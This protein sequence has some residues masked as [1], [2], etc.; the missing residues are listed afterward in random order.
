MGTKV[1]AVVAMT[2]KLVE[3]RKL[4]AN[5]AAYSDSVKCIEG[6]PGELYILL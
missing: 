5:P 4:Q 3:A 2:S 1:L 6:K